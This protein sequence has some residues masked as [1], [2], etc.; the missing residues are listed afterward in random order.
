MFQGPIPI[1]V[2]HAVLARYDL[3]KI[4]EVRPGGGTASPKSIVETERGRFLV[5]RRRAEFCADAVVRFDHAL[6][7]VLHGQGIPCPYPVRTKEGGT[8]VRLHRAVYEVHPWMEGRPFDPESLQ[9]LAAVARILGRFHAATREVQLKGQKAWQ[10]EDHP[11]QI[12]SVL[13]SLLDEGPPDPI[14][15]HVRALDEELACVQERWP[16]E[17][18]RRLPQRIIHGDLHPG[19][20]RFC[21]DRVAGLFDWDWANRQAKI[22]DV[23][24]GLLFFAFRRSTPMDPDDI[25]SLTQ[26]WTADRDRSR[27]FLTAYRE[28]EEITEVE[29]EALPWLLRSRWIQIRVRG[30]R[31]VPEEERWSFLI[32]D[33]LAPLR[34]LACGSAAWLKEVRT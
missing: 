29:W 14:A 26:T 28:H 34:W 16:D 15:K 31:K 21:G 30:M 18:Y 11:D 1:D 22:R 10:R 4:K 2:L 23:S 24:D 9:Q 13:T 12:R 27:I 32:R 8:W 20:V 6:F 25:Y 3:G 17:V 5:R 33:I 7:E 19:N